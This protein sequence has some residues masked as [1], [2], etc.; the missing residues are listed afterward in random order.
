MQLAEPNQSLARRGAE[1]TQRQSLPEERFSARTFCSFRV[2]SHAIP[3]PTGL[4]SRET[5]RREN[6]A[7]VADGGKI[8]R[9]NFLQLSRQLSRLPLSDRFSIERDDRHHVRSGTRKKQLAE[10]RNL[11]DLYRRLVDANADVT[12]GL[13]KHRPGNP[14]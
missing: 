9:Q 1:K 4:P 5:R 6:A 11:F 13:A 14:G 8:F 3:F 2:R 12:G 10:T 7:S